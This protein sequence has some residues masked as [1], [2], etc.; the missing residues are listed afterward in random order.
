MPHHNGIVIHPR[1]IIG[2]NCLIFQQVTIGEHRVGL[3]TIGGHVDIGASAKILGSI[4]IGEHVL[5]GANAVVVKDAP[6][7]C[8]AMGVPAFVSLCS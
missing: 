6:D 2:P 4:R 1:S 8:V 5:I 3:P 7:N